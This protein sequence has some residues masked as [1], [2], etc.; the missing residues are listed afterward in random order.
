MTILENLNVASFRGA[1][2]LIKSHSASGGRKTVNHEYPNSDRR[3]VEDLGELQETFSIQGIIHGDNYFQ[4]RDALITALKT[5]GVGELSHP[6][7][8]TIQC[9]AQPFTLVEDTTTLGIAKFSMTFDKSENAVF[10]RIA[11][12]NEARVNF[13]KN[14][15]IDNINNN[16]GEE[17]GVTRGFSLNF[18]DAQTTLNSVVDSMEVT[19]DTIFKVEDNISDYTNALDTFKDNIVRNIN[20]PL[21]S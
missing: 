14:E 10:P 13:I 1:R 19:A 8:G 17:F 4:D 15:L 3:F 20:N 6:F 21:R 5:P 18:I 2:F 11:T 12:N 7:F 16:L 9:V